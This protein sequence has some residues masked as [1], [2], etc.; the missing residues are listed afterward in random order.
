VVWLIFRR[1]SPSGSRGSPVD[2]QG[3]GEGIYKFVADQPIPGYGDTDD[4][5][6]TLYAPK[7][8]NDEAVRRTV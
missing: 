1:P 6:G 3:T 5:A 4:I 8:A 2:E 7:I